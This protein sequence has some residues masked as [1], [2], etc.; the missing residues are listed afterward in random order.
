MRHVWWKGKVIHSPSVGENLYLSL[1]K[2]LHRQHI[3]CLASMELKYHHEFMGWD[4][5]LLLNISC[6]NIRKK[7]DYAFFKFES[8]KRVGYKQQCNS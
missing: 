1:R 4:G 5:L 6:N 8:I 7:A 3:Y 2:A